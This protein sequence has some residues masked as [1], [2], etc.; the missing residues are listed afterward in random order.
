MFLGA[1]ASVISDLVGP[2]SSHHVIIW[3]TSQGMWPIMDQYRWQNMILLK[4]WTI[5]VIPTCWV[6]ES[7]L[8]FFLFDVSAEPI[9]DTVI[10]SACIV[11]HR[12]PIWRIF[13]KK[14]KKG[15]HSPRSYNWHFNLHSVESWTLVRTSDSKWI[16]CTIYVY[17][18]D[19]VLNSLSLIVYKF[20]GVKQ[21]TINQKPVNS[22]HSTTYSKF[23]GAIRLKNDVKH[24]ASNEMSCWTNILCVALWQE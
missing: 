5:V 10:A 16:T 22:Q 13:D 3:K 1:T 23:R 19:Y 7:M 18:S 21:S 14:T 6:L 15:H 17:A 9:T 8:E 11:V 24:T 12:A 2:F 20:D 4:A